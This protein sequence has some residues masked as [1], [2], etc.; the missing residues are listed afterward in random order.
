M[1][2]LSSGKGMSLFTGKMHYKIQQ[3]RDF[4]STTLSQKIQE[5]KVICILS[6]TYLSST[7]KQITCSKTPYCNANPIRAGNYHVPKQTRGTR[8]LWG[9][10]QRLCTWRDQAQERTGEAEA[11]RRFLG[12]SAAGQQS[13]CQRRGTDSIPGSGRSPG[14]GNGNPL[15]YS[16]L[17]N[18]M[19]RGAWP[20]T[21]H[22]VAMSG[23]QLSNSS[24]RAL[25]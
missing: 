22:R 14:K 16:C 25:E 17:G 11:A 8:A 20:A 23:T 9:N 7:N 18:P 4:M 3:R 13:T 10:T 12:G 24:T 21:V 6:A 15:Q 5:I 19:D 1:A 2:V